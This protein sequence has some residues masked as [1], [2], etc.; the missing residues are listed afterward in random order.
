MM[1]LPSRV[2]ALVLLLASSVAVPATLHAQQ[3][4]PEAWIGHWIGTLTTLSAPDSV[5]NRIPIAGDRSRSRRRRLHV[6]HDLQR[7]HGAT[8]ARNWLGGRERY[9]G[10]MMPPMKATACC[11]TRPSSVAC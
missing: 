5:R 2:R 11:W 8:C 10:G 6:A 1:T 3:R 7:R 9:A 4:F